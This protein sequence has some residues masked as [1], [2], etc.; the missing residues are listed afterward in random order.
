[1]NPFT[2]RALAILFFLSGFASLVYQVVWTRLAFASFGIIAP[3][4]SI[5]LSVFMLGLAVGSW[6][7]GRIIGPLVKKTN[8]S[9]I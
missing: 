1:M 2:R 8:L 6:A 5:V 3:V 9:A 7:G 4:L